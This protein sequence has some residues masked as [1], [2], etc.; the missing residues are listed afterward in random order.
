MSHLGDG[1]RGT[2]LYEGSAGVLCV[3]NHNADS[4]SVDEIRAYL[5]ARFGERFGVNPRRFEEVVASVYKDLGYQTLLT[6]YR[7]DNGIDVFLEKDGDIIGVQ[8][9]RTALAIEAEQI[10]ALTGSLV[11]R[12]ITRGCFVTTSRFRSGAKSAL[13]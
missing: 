9:K 13:D 8:V 7:G 1:F 12:G 4:V 2:R 5:S 10:R 3:L 6:S 11:L